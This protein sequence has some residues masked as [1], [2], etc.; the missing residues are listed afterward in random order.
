MSQ[1]TYADWIQQSSTYIDSRAYHL[2]TNQFVVDPNFGTRNIPFNIL[3]NIE[4]SPRQLNEFVT[5]NSV[6]DNSSD[7]YKAIQADITVQQIRT[8]SLFS[9]VN[10]LAGT[11]FTVITNNGNAY[12]GCQVNEKGGNVSPQGTYAN[13]VQWRCSANVPDNSKITGIY[14]RIGDKSAAYPA[15]V[16]A[17]ISGSANNTSVP[18]SPI[19]I[20]Y[21]SY[22]VLSSPDPNMQLL[23]TQINQNNTIINQNNQII[24]LLEDE[25]EQNQQAYDNISNQ[26]PNDI[27]GSS[28][29]Q[30]TSLINV[31]TGFIGAF[32]GINP[33]NCNLT[34]EF[35][36]YAGGSRVVNIC[37]GKEKAPRIV[38][39]GS[40]LLL[41]CVFV[42]LAFV[43]IRMIYNEI[44][45]WTNG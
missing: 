11:G 40:S 26:S 1:N 42:P 27:N 45:S 18:F 38:E 35:P 23:Q 30:T 8:D 15:N 44:R 21:L 13:Y 43:L 32:S 31:I 25:H 3:T 33:T 34:L 41:I 2:G 37:S 10:T 29:N 20:T 6:S 19:Q 39:I 7:T 17:S 22:N 5:Y 12:G 4:N 16:I 36:D 14:I 28:D 9:G 24:N